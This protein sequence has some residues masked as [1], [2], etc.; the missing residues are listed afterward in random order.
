MPDDPSSLDKLVRRARR[1][2][3]VATRAV[4]ELSRQVSTRSKPSQGGQHAP[5]ELPGLVYLHGYEDSRPRVP[6]PAFPPAGYLGQLHPDFQRQLWASRAFVTREDCDFYHTS[7]LPGGEVIPGAWDL[8][9]HEPEYLGG[10][11]LAGR[12]VLELGPAT[13]HLTFYLERIGAGVVG[14]DVGWDRSVD[15]LPRPG[16]EL[17]AARM[18]VMRYVGTMQNSWWYLHREYDS[19]VPMMYGN[20]YDLPGDLPRFHSALF[21]A[22]LLHL[23]DPFMAL[24]SVAEWV[25]EQIIVTQ[26][27]EIEDAGPDDNVM[28]FAPQ[29]AQYTTHWWAI[30]PGAVRR[31]LDRLGFV[32][33]ELTFHEQTH[34]LGHDMDKPPIRMKMFTV[35]GRRR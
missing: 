5:L 7:E 6:W 14:F 1:A 17:G 27:M 23:R 16:V 9:G 26:P 20:I 30:G 10:V 33:Q 21:A 12:S 35:V 18:D 13:G 24:A 32:E 22:I 19:K 2:K 25:D 34:H 11:D 8:R 4:G 31:M 15:L 3:A 29:D 28:R